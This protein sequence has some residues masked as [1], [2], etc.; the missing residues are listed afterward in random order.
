MTQSGQ[1]SL[2]TQIARPAN[3][4]HSP[5]RADAPPLVLA[6]PLPLFVV[7]VTAP[8]ITPKSPD[9]VLPSET[10]KPSALKPRRSS[11]RTAAAR[12]GMWRPNRQLSR[13]VSSCLV[14][15]ICRRSPRGSV[16]MSFLPRLTTIKLQ[17]RI[18]INLLKFGKRSLK[19]IICKY[20]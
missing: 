11:S 20:R 13:A 10:A 17:L 12:L 8:E 5:A 4:D 6:A 18:L 19:L 14:S 16:V 15:M 2:R 9:F 7:L 1:P 3:C